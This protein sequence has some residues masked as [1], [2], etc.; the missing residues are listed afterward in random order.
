MMMQQFSKT[1][2]RIN[3]SQFNLIELWRQNNNWDKNIIYKHIK[4]L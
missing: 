1:D 3:T 4:S 2:P